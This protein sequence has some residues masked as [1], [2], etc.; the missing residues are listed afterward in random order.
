[1][2]TLPDG[3]ARDKKISTTLATW[4]TALTG[5]VSVL[6]ATALAV[7]GHAEVALGVLATG[8]LT[9]SVEVKMMISVHR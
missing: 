4:L 2:T 8:G 7:Q 6:A 9:T 5:V 1:M 3:T